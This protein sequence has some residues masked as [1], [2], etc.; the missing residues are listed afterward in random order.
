MPAAGQR[1]RSPFMAWAV[2]A[3]MDIRRLA[4]ASGL[5]D[6]R[7]HLIPL[8]AGHLDVREDQIEKFAL[9]TFQSL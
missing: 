9:V 8:H 5:T 4:Q 2:K 1:S 6:G 7:S 3:M